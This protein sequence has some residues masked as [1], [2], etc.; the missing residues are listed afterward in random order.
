MPISD[1]L[2]SEGPGVGATDEPPSSPEAPYEAPASPSSESVVSLES[3][4]PSV[5]GGGVTDG[6]PSSPVDPYEAPASAVGQHEEASQT[7]AQ[8]APDPAPVPGADSRPAPHGTRVRPPATL[9]DFAD[10][11]TE[12]LKQRYLEEYRQ[13]FSDPSSLHA[14][15]SILRALSSCA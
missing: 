7:G 6:P 12:L 4:L 9:D 14:V 1:G 3:L 11:E 2:S 10:R 13:K 8:S 5:P 15:C